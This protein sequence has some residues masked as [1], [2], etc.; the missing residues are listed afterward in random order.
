MVAS[1]RKRG[2]RRT[3]EGRARARRSELLKLARVGA[4]GL[5]ESEP[6]R[7]LARAVQGRETA[8]AT[9]A[10]SAAT[11]KAT[12]NFPS[13]S[14]PA[15]PQAKTVSSPVCFA[16]LESPCWPPLDRP[17]D[18]QCAFPSSPSAMPRPLP[19]HMAL[20]DFNARKAVA[21]ELVSSPCRP[22]RGL[23]QREGRAP[24]PP[25]AC[26]LSTPL[27]VSARPNSQRA[28]P[29]RV[30]VHHAQR[31]DRPQGPLGRHAQAQR[32]PPECALS[33]FVPAH[34]TARPRGA[35]LIHLG[36]TCSD[37]A[38]GGQEPVCR[39]GPW[40][41]CLQRVWSL[42]RA[43]RLFSRLSSIRGRHLLMLNFGSQHRFKLN[44]EE[45][46]IPGVSRASW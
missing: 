37:A 32:L 27:T 23:R 14:S 35:E 42:P 2:R 22:G 30:P 4:G 17:A 8:A 29:S 25:L 19:G 21:G 20:K 44:A 46:N 18:V 41:R 26:Y 1:E 33:G 38:G 31:D 24:G 3:R 10:R 28:A 11:N 45:G 12:R 40:R 16:A 15:S 7:R 36:R 43:S 34:L 5:G 39:D 9:R 13:P 6:G